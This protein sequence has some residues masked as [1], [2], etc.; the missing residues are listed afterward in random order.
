ELMLLD[1]ERQA[2]DRE[3]GGLDGPGELTADLIDCDVAMAFAQQQ[4]G[5]PLQADLT[6]QRLADLLADPAHLDV[7]GV[8]RKQGAARLHRGKQRG[9]VADET[10]AGH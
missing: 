10:L 8:E 5:T 3:E 9:S 2:V 1:Q 6:R 4:V 7:E